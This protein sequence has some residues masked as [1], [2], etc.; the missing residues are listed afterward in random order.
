M[1]KMD[2]LT[3]LEPASI[4]G[5]NQVPKP[6]EPQEDGS[7]AQNRTEFYGLQI[8]CIASNASGE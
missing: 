6:F 2:F 4:L 1:N 8:R 7:P 5:C 3:G